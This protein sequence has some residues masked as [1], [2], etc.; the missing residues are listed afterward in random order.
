MSQFSLTSLLLVSILGGI[1][2]SAHSEDSKQPPAMPVD[3]DALKNYDFDEDEESTSY[4]GD[5]YLD[6]PYEPEQFDRYYSMAR[7]AF[8]FGYYDTALQYW[9]PMANLGYA[10]AQ[11]SIAWMYHAGKGFKQNYKRAFEW[12]MKAALQNHAIAQNNLGVLYEKGWGTRRNLTKAAKW[13]KE[14]AEWGYSYG[15]FNYGKL[16]QDGRGVRRNKKKANYWLNLA[17][18]QGVD[19]ASALIGKTAPSQISRHIIDQSASPSSRL[20]KKVWILMK[21]PRYFTLYLMQ[22]KS[23]NELLKYIELSKNPGPFA[24]F[25]TEKKGKKVFHLIYGVYPTFT[26]AEQN[27]RKLPASMTKIKPSIRK[28]SNIQK[29][30]KKKIR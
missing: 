3:P 12:Y 18:I 5:Y 26:K 21:N 30:I 22:G 20:K 23:K 29:D 15:Q 27:I 10:K 19:Q 8:L 2:L 4:F 25:E 28:F 16:L 1:P 14:S 17:S 11:A 7:M 6:E 13:Y 9:Q 24:Y